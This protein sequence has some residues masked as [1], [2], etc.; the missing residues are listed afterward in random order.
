M[1]AW[2]PDLYLRFKS[3]RTQPT[4]DL[5][6]RIDL[7]SPKSIADLGC[8][9]GNSTAVLRQR[10]P[11]SHILGLD[12]SEA[13][14]EKARRDYPEI[15]WKLGDAAALDGEYDLVFS[16]AALQWIPDHERL[17]PYLMSCVR[18]GGA[19]ASQISMF[20]DMPLN[21]AIEAVAARSRWCEATWSC[22]A[23]FTYREPAFYYRLLSGLAGRID[24]WTTSYYHVLDSRSALVDF[25]RSTALKP[26]LERLSSE[27]ER[28]DFEGEL[29][30]ELESRYELQSDGKVLFPFD[31]QFFVAYKG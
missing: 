23:L 25:C 7:V 21:L 11:Q 20:K 15:E 30:D 5:V 13:M 29:F 8:G 9:P 26:Y 12:S 6:S 31:R 19:L 14:I 10:W 16:N 3:E 24:M 22:A 28:A 4:I 18:S 17:L 27:G 1:S 2:N